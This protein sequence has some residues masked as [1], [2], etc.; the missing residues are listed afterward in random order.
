MSFAWKG[1]T[2]FEVSDGSWRE[3]VREGPRRALMTPEGV[4]ALLL[5]APLSWTAGREYVPGFLVAHDAETELDD[6]YYA[7][8]RVRADGTRYDVR[9]VCNLTRTPQARE[10]LL[11]HSAHSALF[12]VE[13]FGQ[14]VDHD[15]L[16]QFA[17]FPC[18]FV[19]D[20]AEVT[21]DVKMVDYLKVI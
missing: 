4:R 14:S 3:F 12:G 9:R 5:P 15:Q 10:I 7:E 2:R 13:V 19:T 11:A 6:I 21:N 8:S 20:D 16:F 1:K 17:S 18:G